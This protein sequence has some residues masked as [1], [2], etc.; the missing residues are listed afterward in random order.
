M[1]V[2]TDKTIHDLW[3]CIRRIEIH[4]L[5][6]YP[7]FNVQP[8]DWTA[9]YQPDFAATFHFDCRNDE[10]TVG[11]FDLYSVVANMSAHHVVSS[12]GILECRGNE[13]RDHNNSCP[14]KLEYE[15]TIEYNLEE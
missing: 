2:Y 7:A 8:K 3:P 1:R 6:K 5:V 13:A 10:C 11:Y 12:S 14:C 15:V 9:V 4:A